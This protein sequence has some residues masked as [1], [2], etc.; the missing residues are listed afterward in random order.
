MVLGITFVL[1]EIIK[2]A[3][4]Q[5][6]EAKTNNTTPRVVGFAVGFALTA[7]FWPES[8]IDRNLMALFIGVANPVLYRLIKWKWPKAAAAIEQ[9][10]KERDL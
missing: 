5:W 1:T 7:V 9:E 4:R 8:T 3:I 10:T 6:T 2:S